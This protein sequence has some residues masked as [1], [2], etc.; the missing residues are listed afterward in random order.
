M[1]LWG[2]GSVVKNLPASVGNARD[3]GLIPGLGTSL[4]E[5]NSNDSG[6]L[7]WKFHGRRYLASYGP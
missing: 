7:A 2:F 4:G 5:G 3:G 6:I 1:I